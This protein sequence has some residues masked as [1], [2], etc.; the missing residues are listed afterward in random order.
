MLKKRLALL[1]ATSHIAKDLVQSLADKS[2]HEVVLYSR[3]PDEVSR[4]II[5]LGL[6]DRYISANFTEFSTDE[7]FDAILNFVGVGDPAKAAEMGASIF[8]VT[9]KYDELALEYLRQRRDCRY[10]FMSSGAAYGSSFIEPVDEK[11][12]A[13]IAINNLQSQDWYSVAKLHA[14]CRHRSLSPLSI[15]DIRIFNYFS[16]TQDI[17]AQFFISDIVRAIRNK[18]ILKTSLDHMVRDFIGPEDF[19]HLIEAILTSTPINTVVDCYSKSPIDKLSLLNEM[20]VN[21]GLQYKILENINPV[22][23]T[24]SKPNYYSLNKRA[25]SL[26]YN[27]K[28]TS[29]STINKELKILLKNLKHD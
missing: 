12:N 13:V 17:E 22:N 21:F 11:T 2:R 14:E 8:D 18:T 23:A 19:Y 29:L 20:E 1:G 6:A 10:I 15:I 7:R 25:T 28:Y 27:P 16:S 26:N 4:W 9:L 5:S 3:R 24:G